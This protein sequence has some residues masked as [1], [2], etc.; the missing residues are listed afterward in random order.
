MAQF[1][2]VAGR[3]IAIEVARPPITAGKHKPDLLANGTRIDDALATLAART[4][5]PPCRHCGQLSFD[6]IGKN[7]VAL[8][9]LYEQVGEIVPIEAL[10]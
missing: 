4:C 9:P 7:P 1:V 10:D 6:P 8:E 2:D 5:R 3:P